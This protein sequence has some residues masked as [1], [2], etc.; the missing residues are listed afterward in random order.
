MLLP[1]PAARPF[2]V[3]DNGLNPYI[4][5]SM[6]ALDYPIRCVQDE[7]DAPDGNIDDPTIVNHIADRYGIHGVW[8]TKDIS[9]K[10]AHMSLIKARQ[11]SVI[12]IQK[13]SLSTPQQH[14]IITYGFAQVFQDLVESRHPIHYLVSFHGQLNRERITYKKQ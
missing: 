7:F 6:A 9:A 14:R 2:F 3:L 4:A 10:R 12:W 5:R 1:D 11:I 13:Q 8:I